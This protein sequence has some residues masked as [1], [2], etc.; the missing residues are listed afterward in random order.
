M[1]HFKSICALLMC[2]LLA[3]PFAACGGNQDG[4][5]GGN[6]GG[7]QN[8]QGTQDGSQSGNEQEG[9][10][11]SQSGNE[12]EG[13]GG[14]QSGNEQESQG[15]SQSGI[16]QESQG[17]NQNQP[18]TPS[19]GFPITEEAPGEGPQSK[20]NITSVEGVPLITL[21]NGV[22]MPRFGLGTQI[23]ELENGDLGTLNRTSRECVAAALEA[24]YRHLDDAHGYLNERGVAQ[25]IKDSGVPREEIWIT[26]KLWPSEY[27]NAATAIDQ[28]LDRLDVEYIDLLY[29]H[30]PAGSIATIES[31][32]RAMEDAYRE[33][34]IRALGISN[35]DN[36]MEA[37]N[38]IMDEEIKPQVMQ[39]ECHP[40]AQRVETR[41]LAAQYNIQ[42]ECWYPLKHADDTLLGDTTLEEIAEAHG[43]SVVQ[44]IVRWHI[45][46]GFSVIP[47][48]TNPAH[49]QENIQ[50]FDFKLSDE[51]MDRIRALDRGDRGRSFRLQYGNSAGMFGSAPREWNGE[52]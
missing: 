25:G 50:V 48:S 17:G 20:S 23:Q 24:G 29:L 21:N 51:E 49:I 16:E 28:M 39:I 4:G 18:E 5:Q 31:A 6:Q 1:K 22:Q 15:G 10:G 42:V 8:E 40:M 35:F 46:E 11:G 12:Q 34:K 13:Q 26:D 30:H 2:L 36:R 43:K 32:W 9:Q 52:F 14:S 27:A 38:A 44:V 33:G 45:Q 3:F 37:F 47:G 19:S 41:E 7:T